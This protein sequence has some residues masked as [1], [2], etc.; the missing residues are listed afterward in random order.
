MAEPSKGICRLQARKSKIGQMEFSRKF[1]VC[2]CACWCMCVCLCV[3]GEGGRGVHQ[4]SR[5]NV[6]PAHSCIEQQSKPAVNVNLDII[7]KS[8]VN[9]PPNTQA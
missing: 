8:E 9:N 3:C 6:G 7:S 4:H 2:V 1:E 5:S